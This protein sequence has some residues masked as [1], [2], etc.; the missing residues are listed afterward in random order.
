M[1][2][3]TTTWTFGKEGSG[4]YFTIVRDASGAFSV[5]MLEGSM[6]LNALWFSDGDARREGQYSLSKNDSSLSM[7]GDSRSDDKYSSSKSGSSLGK[8]DDACKEGSSSHSKSDSSSDLKESS[9]EH[10]VWDDMIKLS[11]TGLGKAGLSKSTFLT[12]GETLSLTPEQLSQLSGGWIPAGDDWSSVTLGVR[13]T[14]VNGSKGDKGIKLT[15]TGE[16]DAGTPPSSRIFV[17]AEDGSYLDADGDGAFDYAE[18][19]AGPLDWAT[20]NLGAGAHTV[21]FVG[22]GA[23]ALATGPIDL[24]GFDADDRVV[25]DFSQTWLGTGWAGA[26]TTAPGVLTMQ[27]GSAAAGIFTGYTPGFATAKPTN[28]MPTGPLEGR[29]MVVQPGITTPT[30]TPGVTYWARVK[31]GSNSLFVTER[32]TGGPKVPGFPSMADNIHTLAKFGSGVAVDVYKQF[33]VIWPTATPA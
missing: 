33:D 18:Y 5:S 10:T 27:R 8:S 32:T 2:T 30:P 22:W 14:A 24:T 9:S 11:S 16:Y 29:Q 20:V 31:F 25:V 1:A 19:T 6:D 15:A 17:T 28:G 3:A 23:V 7:N 4:L 26:A 12:T 13:S 21:H